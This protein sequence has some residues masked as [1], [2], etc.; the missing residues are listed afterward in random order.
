[1]K[2]SH[3]FASFLMALCPLALVAA[4]F[5]SSAAAQD[6]RWWIVRAEYGTVS[7]HNNV[8]D[9]LKDLIARGGVNGRLVVTNQTMGGDPAVGADKKLRIWARNTRNHEREFD[10]REDSFVLI[11]MFVVHR[12]DWDD[13]DRAHDHDDRSRNHGGHEEQEYN[14]LQILRAFYGVKGR[15]EDVTRVL[16]NLVR[17]GSLNFVVSNRDLGIDPAPGAD[18]ILIV[19]YR[20]RGIETATAVREG[21]MLTIP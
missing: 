11:D 15:T 20:Y 18:K 13:R 5:S 14:E 19:V 3:R 21:K 4:T 9:L 10:F 17:G 7:Q 6:E 8:T 16:R 12:D 1:M 2:F